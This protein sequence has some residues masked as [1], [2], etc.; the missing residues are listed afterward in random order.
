MFL[1]QNIFQNF[2][3]FFCVAVGGPFIFAIAQVSVQE[4]FSNTGNGCSATGYSYIFTNIYYWARIVSIVVN[5]VVFISVSV[6]LH[7]L[8]ELPQMRDPSANDSTPALMTLI[9]R[10]KYYPLIQV[11]IRRYELLL[12]YLVYINNRIWFAVLY[13]SGAAWNEFNNYQYQTF[14]SQ[15]MNSICS[16]SSGACYFFLF[17]VGGIMYVCIYVCTV[18]GNTVTLSPSSARLNDVTNVCIYL[19][20]YFF[21]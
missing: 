4:N 10:M 8:S 3:F 15:L 17:L 1:I 21:V 18:F 14:A 9:R 7:Y 2:P 19:C 13:C 20:M 12:G 11:L 5:A 16:P 6:R